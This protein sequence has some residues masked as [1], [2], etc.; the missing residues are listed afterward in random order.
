MRLETTI[1]PR[2]DGVVNVE[3]DGQKYV[4]AADESGAMVCDVKH[5]NHAAHLLKQGDNFLP[6]DEADFVKAAELARGDDDSNDGNDDD[7][8]EDPVDMNAAPIEEPASVVAAEPAAPKAG[9]K[10]KGA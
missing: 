8:G 5:D 1:S 6:Y 3:I 4:F 9:R 2:R 10:K 7:D